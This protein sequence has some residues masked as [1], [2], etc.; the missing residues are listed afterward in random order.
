MIPTLQ[1][2]GLGL[3]RRG[4]ASGGVSGFA[5]SVLAL[6]PWGYWKLDETG[7]VTTASAADSSSNARHGNYVFGAGSPIANTTALY[8]GSTSAI[9]IGGTDA[10]VSLPSFALPVEA[11]QKV[12]VVATIKSN[13][14]AITHILSADGAVRAWQFRHDASGEI[15][16]VTIQGAVVISGNTAIANVNDNAAHMV[17]F[18]FDGSLA[19]DKVKLYL[20]GSRVYSSGAANPRMPPSVS[21]PIAI[22]SQNNTSNTG[23]GPNVVDEVALFASALTDADFADLWAERNTP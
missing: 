8:S 4:Q 1:I 14:A 16:L 17:G 18:T 19:T 11:S 23:G 10:R 2:G 13:R 5:A 12:S 21:A 6:S 9:S 3:Q 20:D 15:Q 7:I 22:A